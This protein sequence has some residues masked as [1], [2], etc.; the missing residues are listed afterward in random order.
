MAAAAIDRALAA[1]ELALVIK[2]KCPIRT[3]FLAP[4]ISAATSA[5][6][7]AAV[8]LKCFWLEISKLVKEKVVVQKLRDWRRR[9]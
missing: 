8:L 1:D 2:T 6:S 5:D 7:V 3:P 4:R 9:E